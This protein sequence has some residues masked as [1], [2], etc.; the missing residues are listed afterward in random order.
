MLGAETACCST[1]GAPFLLAHFC[2]ATAVLGTVSTCLDCRRPTFFEQAV[3]KPT[4][5]SA[6]HALDIDHLVRAAGNK[7][8]TFTAAMFDTETLASRGGGAVCH[9]A[10]LLLAS[11]VSGAMRF[12]NRY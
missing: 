1:S 5:R 3:T 7:A 2:T 11:A 6:G 8:R 10:R 4:V 9:G 12:F